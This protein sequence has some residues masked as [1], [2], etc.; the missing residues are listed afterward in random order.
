MNPLTE[1]LNAARELQKILQENP[2][3]VRFAEILSN[4]KEM[5]LPKTFDNF[6]S[7]A[8]AAKV[9]GVSRSLIYAYKERGLLTAYTLPD[10]S[11]VRFKASDVLALAKKEE[12]NNG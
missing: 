6:I 10:S 4:Q 1:T 3:I 8:Q 7:A 2:D 12:Q 5:I 9:L 11:R